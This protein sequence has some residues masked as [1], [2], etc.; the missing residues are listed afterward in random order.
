[1]FY[2]NIDCDLHKKR[3][4]TCFV[5]L[6]LCSFLPL[7]A[8]FKF[9]PQKIRY[10]YKITLK[11]YLNEFI[12]SFQS[13]MWLNENLGLDNY[14]YIEKCLLDIYLLTDPA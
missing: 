10:K 3:I 8:K 4:K 12:A 2:I 13:H 11:R 7:T 9:M 14:A 5:L 1:M 6:A